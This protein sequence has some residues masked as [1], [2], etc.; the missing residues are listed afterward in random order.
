ME[1]EITN[2]PLQIPT[3]LQTEV[4]VDLLFGCESGASIRVLNRGVH[5]HLLSIEIQENGEA[6]AVIRRLS[7]DPDQQDQ[8]DR[9]FLFD[10]RMF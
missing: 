2:L 4:M 3:A 8:A 7:G 5:M 6:F 10:T 1:I 9:V